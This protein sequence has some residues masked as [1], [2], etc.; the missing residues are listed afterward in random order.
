[1]NKRIVIKIGTGVI[2][3]KRKLNRTFISEL[4]KGVDKLLKDG[5]E[6]IIVSSGAIGLGMK[7]LGLKTRP[8]ALKKLQ[9]LA[10]IGQLELMK[11]YEKY[12][13]RYKVTLG[14]V[15]VTRGDFTNR[16]SYLNLSKTLFT[17]LK[18]GIVP[19]IN[20]NDSVA[21]EEIKFGDNDIL[22]AL[23]ASKM[24]CSK[25]V[26]FTV[27]DGVI[28]GTEV[29]SEIKKITSEILKECSGKSQLGSG[30]MYSKI[31]AS[32]IA[33]S[34]GITTLILNGKN[35]SLLY[36][37]VLGKIKIGTIVHPEKKLK[38]RKRWIE[39][40][41][42]E[43]GNIVVDEGAERVLVKNGKSLLA[44]GIKEVK[45]DFSRGDVV[46]I[47]NKKGNIIG[48]GISNYSIREVDKIKGRNSKEIEKV[49]GYKK[50]EEIIHRDNMVIYND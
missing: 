4:A 19:V 31:Q 8:N 44:S 23:I 29:I 22:S 13:S 46:N 24:D 36:D 37:I 43:K 49:L 30:G 7:K 3:E 39:F 6:V 17:L 20:E 9:S 42:I 38:S 34:S 18:W 35:V 16:N 27:V 12:F 2:F 11:Q 28:Q 48:K 32:K 25:L 50:E 5:Y 47:L 21:V 15:L 45:G 14:Q 1:M 33:Q 41:S 26:I 40:C 10:S